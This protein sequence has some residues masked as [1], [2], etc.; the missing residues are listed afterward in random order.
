MCIVHKDKCSF[1]ILVLEEA[2]GQR[3][4]T[5]YTR[6]LVNCQNH[7]IALQMFCG[8][9]GWFVCFG[10]GVFY[11]FIIKFRPHMYVRKQDGWFK[12][13]SRSQILSI[14]SAQFSEL[15]QLFIN[16][17]WMENPGGQAKDTSIWKPNFTINQILHLCF[18]K[19]IKWSLIHSPGK[20]L[21]E[22]P[23]FP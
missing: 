9:F 20:P 3:K 21:W 19:T 7:N 8:F 15:T 10:G 23:F 11:C 13:F 1:H 14:R 6:A 17:S 22:T 18:S 4:L 12:H 2:S 16:R 5:G